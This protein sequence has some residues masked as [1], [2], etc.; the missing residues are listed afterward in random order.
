[1]ITVFGNFEKSLSIGCKNATAEVEGELAG[2]VTYTACG[3]ELQQQVNVL[4]GKPIILGCIEPIY[5]ADSWV[6]VD[7]LG[8]CES[9]DDSNTPA[10]GFLED[11]F[12]DQPISEYS[13]DV[14]DGFNLYMHSNVAWRIELNNLNLF[15]DGDTSGPPY[16]DA[17]DHEL[18]TFDA[19]TS[20]TTLINLVND[21]DGSV[22]DTVT[23][24][25]GGG[26][27]GS[28]TGAG[29]TKTIIFTNTGNVS[30]Y[31]IAYTYDKADGTSV[32][33]GSPI[34]AGE[35]H[36]AQGTVGYS[37]NTNINITYLQE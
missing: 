37:F 16:T 2:T 24:T 3:D 33:Q 23:V 36:S 34:G 7:V 29:T 28:G 5:T 22:L 10:A 27:A 6:N 4:P 30:I 14:G 20:G 8:N 13:I 26:D 18:G 35:A 1:M 9:G 15:N 25:I 11:A 32:S 31:P 12:T 17:Y 19:I 21:A